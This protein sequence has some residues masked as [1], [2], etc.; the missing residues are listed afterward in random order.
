M[1]AVTEITDNLMSR[2]PEH[3]PVTVEFFA[4]LESPVSRSAS[5][6]L[7]EL[8]AKYP[9]AIR[10]QFRNF[11]LAFHPQAAMAHEAAMLAAKQ[12]HFWEIAN[13]IFDHQD[14]LREQDLIAYAGSLGLDQVKFAEAL[15]QKNYSPRV[16]ADREDGARRGVRGSPVIFVNAKR[17]DGVP[18]LRMLTDYVEAELA[19]KQASR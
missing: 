19:S 8:T 7:D 10:L 17:I 1:R 16:D 4:D 12:G 2:G 13:Y 18:S 11:P 3:A 14:G 9:V 6:V 15:R 5:Y